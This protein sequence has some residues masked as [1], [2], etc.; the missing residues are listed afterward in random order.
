MFDYTPTYPSQRS[1][2]M[3]RNVVATSQPL[4]AQAGLAMMQ[5]G[6]NAVDAAIATAICLTIVEPTMNGIGSDAFCILWDGQS[7]QGLNASGRAPAAWSPARFAGRD[8]MPL[9][10]WDAVTVPGA[11]SQWV[12]LS[13]RYGKLPFAQLFE[14]AIHYARDGFA[15][16]PVVAR[17]WAMAAP[18]LKDQP[19]WAEHFMR[20]GRTP[21]AG[22]IFK[23]EDQARTLE[24]IAQSKGEAFYRGALAEKMIAH[25][26]AHGGAMTM[27]DLAAH[28]CDWVG[29]LA[30][31]YHGV[32]LHEIPPNGQGI[33]ALIAAGVLEHLNIKQHALDSTGF[34]HAMMEAMR[35]GFT[36]AYEHVADE[37]YLRRKSHELL[38]PDFLKT[39]AVGTSSTQAGSYAGCV[40]PRG[41]TVYLTTAD[42]S[43]M[44]VSFIQSNYMGFG[45]G[46]VVPGTGIAL[47]NR[48]AGFTLKK[49]HANEVGSGKRPRHTIVPAF[50]TRDGK[51]LCSFGVMGGVMQPQ[52]HLQMLVRMLD[53]GQNPQTALDAPRFCIQEDGTVKMESHFGEPQFEALKNMGHP[54][55]RTAPHALDYGAGQIIWRM[56]NGQYVAGS[57][58]RRDGGV[59]GV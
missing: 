29:T 55:I 27:D 49:G 21:H 28:T 35:V 34:W 37:K 23:S 38:T 52:G 25:A 13:R 45:S 33:A 36:H 16:S 56:E 53:Y 47:Q 59:V 39:C 7:V 19:G 11:V 58:M 57:D 26:R 46:V 9:Y 51:P 3:A 8:A 50:I 44:M 5:R 48:G 22:E 12:E 32:E 2:V 4:A 6:G 42:A 24:A 20:N 40:P 10:G 14:P 1:S 17:Q 15:V 18:K 31:R 41:G 43:G 54:V 30:Q